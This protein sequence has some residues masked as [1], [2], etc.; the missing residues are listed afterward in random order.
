MLP[1][2]LN[3]DFGNPVLMGGCRQPTESEVAL[4]V[5]LRDVRGSAV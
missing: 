1:F 4:K 3:G 2:T 5:V